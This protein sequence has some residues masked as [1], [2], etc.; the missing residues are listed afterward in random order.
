M[1]DNCVCDC[2][3]E[4][5]PKCALDLASKFWTGMGKSILPNQKTAR[6]KKILLTHPW[7]QTTLV[8]I[9]LDSY[10]WC[11]F[12]LNR[13]MGGYKILCASNREKDPSRYW[14]WWWNCSCIYNTGDFETKSF[15]LLPWLNMSWHIFSIL[16]LQKQSLALMM[17]EEP[18]II[19]I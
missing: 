9:F 14:N 7:P 4:P 6:S 15:S 3:Q 19:A 8:T 12:L 1:E 16:V 13:C 18:Q 5:P 2:E 17:F 10:D 11:L